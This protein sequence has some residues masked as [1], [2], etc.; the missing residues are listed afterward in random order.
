M[1][2]RWSSVKYLTS[3]C[4]VCLMKLMAE[5]S[6]LIIRWMSGSQISA[7]I[8]LLV[9]KSS[10][11]EDDW[12]TGM[13]GGV[14]PGWRVFIASNYCPDKDPSCLIICELVEPPSDGLIVTTETP[15]LW[16][17]LVVCPIVSSSKLHP[18][19]F[20][21]TSKLDDNKSLSD[22]VISYVAL[23]KVVIVCVLWL[24]FLWM[25]MFLY[26]GGPESL[27]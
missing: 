23:K 18:L 26:S 14:F 3:F 27:S 12:W 15:L 5:R 17:V 6:H 20:K 7:V 21:S 25:R 10:V 2:I 24:L 4:F 9:K 8:E 22:I 11:C 1:W 19:A 16:L 13:I